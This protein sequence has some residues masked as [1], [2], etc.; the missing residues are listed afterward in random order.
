MENARNLRLVAAGIA[1][2]GTSFGLAPLRL[3]VAAARDARELPAVER[4]A[5]PDRHRVLRGLPRRA[6]RSSRLCATR[7]GAAVPVVIG[8]LLAV[9]GM[10]LV[11]VARSPAMLGAGR[12]DRGSERRRWPI[13]RSPTRS[14]RDVPERAPGPRAGVH[15]LRH[16]L[17]RGAGRADRAVIAGSNWRA[18]WVAF[19]VVGAAR[20]G[21]RRRGARRAKA[22]VTSRRPRRSPPLSWSWFVCPRSGPA[23]DRR[24]A[25]GRR[26]V[27]VLDV[28]GRLRRRAAICPAAAG[29]VLLA[30][31]GAVEHPRL[32]RGRHARAAGRAARALRVSA[33][34]ACAHRCSCCAAAP[35]S[36]VVGRQR[37]RARSARPTTCC[38]RCRSIWSGRVFA[39]RPSTGLAADAVH[40]WGSGSSM[41]PALAGA[42]ADG[43]GLARRVLRRWATIALAALL[44]PREELRRA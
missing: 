8:G 25:G 18:A 33:I 4:D 34:G 15:L 11:A 16:G 14:P 24:A 20:H 30:A 7:L 1:M 10:L 41:G 22:P 29:A 26:R 28:R 38:W 36:W 40:A 5:R 44:P 43:V 3:R 32:V 21:L 37:R 39:E 6:R 13:P 12:A 23:A 27:G 42:L 9:A 19:A 35:S 31:V 2:V 17:G